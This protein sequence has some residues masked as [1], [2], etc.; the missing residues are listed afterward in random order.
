MSMFW[1]IWVIVIT[2]IVLLGSVWLLFATRK[3][4]VVD[5]KSADGDNEDNNGG[6]N[7]DNDQSLADK[8]KSEPQLLTTGHNY[9]GIEEYDNPLPRWW[10]NLFLITAIFGFVYLILYPGFGSYPGLLK[11]TSVNEWQQDI[12]KAELQTAEIFSQYR[13]KPLEEV[14]QIPEAMKTAQRLFNNNCSVCHG[15]DGRGSYGFPNLADN[16]WL[17]GGRPAAIESSIRHG[18]QGVMPGWGQ[19]VGEGGVGHLTDY[20]FSLSEREH[21]AESAASGKQAFATY[22]AACH[23]ADA[24]GNVALGAPNLT[25]SIWLY[26]GSPLLVMQSIRDGRNGNMPAQQGLIKD[27]KI[28]LLAAYVYRLSKLQQ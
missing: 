2:L 21:N 5:A 28:H 1:S 24:K 12:D 10:F 8:S 23:G 13:D 17:Y 26:G 6:N 16:D 20:L 19:V 25:D 14:A 27:D 3:I 18:R 11:W 15:S 7:S 4:T 22:C 9:D